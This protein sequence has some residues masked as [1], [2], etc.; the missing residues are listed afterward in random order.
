VKRRP[1]SLAAQLFRRT[2]LLVALIGVAMGSLTYWVARSQIHHEADNELVT[3][4]NVLYALM[5]DELLQERVTPQMLSIDDNLLSGEDLRAF[6]MSADRRMFAIF[7]DR[8]AIMRSDTAPVGYLIPQQ[9]GFSSITTP[10]GTWRI[11]GLAVPG[12]H[13]SIQV[14][15]RVSVR[16]MVLVEIA[17]NIAIPLI[18]LIIGSAGLFWLSLQDGLL[19]LR[20]LSQILSHRSPRD[21]RRLQTEDWPEDLSLLVTT[22]ND[23]FA[24]VDAAFWRERQFTDDAAHQLR[25]PL[26]AL[27][28]QVQTLARV[29]DEK[30][31]RLLAAGL[32]ETVDRASLLVSRMLTLARLDAGEAI[33][34]QLDIAAILIECVADQAGIAARRDV[35]LAFEGPRQLTGD[36]DA[37]ALR[38]IFSNLIENAVKHAPTGSTVMVAIRTDD[39]GRAVITVADEGPGIAAPE[40]LRVLQRFHRAGGG[41]G[42]GGAGTGLGLAIVA[43]AVRLLG[44]QLLLD[45]GPGERGLLVTVTLPV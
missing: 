11:Y 30:E 38:L 7:R 42:D 31:R 18:F 37:T 8:R 22:L 5:Q 15:E 14:G 23:L 16:D 13:L 21:I 39:Q 40:R 24:R 35:A 12:Y 3:A 27:K 32:L 17:K 19:Q 20:Q 1:L 26:A 25:T 28:I 43:S 29:E 10:A 45:A 33:A 4:A 2:I 34:E 6:R 9:K 41:D 44:G 36:S